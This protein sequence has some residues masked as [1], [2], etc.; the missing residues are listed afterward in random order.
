MQHWPAQQLLILR[1]EDMYENPAPIYSQVTEFLELDPISPAEF[2]AWNK[3]AGPSLP[4]DQ[5]RRLYEELA[6]SIAATEQLLDRP[7]EWR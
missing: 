1:S 7:L 4:S 6:P 5:H 3:Q 2:Q